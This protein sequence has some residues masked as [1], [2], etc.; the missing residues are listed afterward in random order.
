LNSSPSL[1]TTGLGGLDPAFYWD[2]GF[3]INKVPVPPFVD[4][5]FANGQGGP[6][7]RPKDAN[8]LSYSQQWNLTIERQ[9]TSNLMASVAY[10]ANKGTRLPSQLSPINVLNPN[11]LQT[12]GASALGDQFGPNDTVVNGVPVP[13]AGWYD[14]LTNYGCTPTVAQALSPYPQ[15]CGGL[16]GLNENL[17]SST[18]HSFQLKVEKRFSQGLY[19]LLAYTHSKLLTSAAGLTQS[20]SASWNGTTG[21]IIS[22]FEWNRN[23]SLA[24]DDVPNSFSLAGTYELP[25]GKGKKFANSSNGMNYLVGGWQLTGAWKYS[26]GTPFWFRAANCNVP[27]QFRLT[28]IPAVNSGQD[29][30][31]VPLDQYDPGS[32]KP[33]FNAAA[34]EPD[35]LFTS[36]NYYG[37]GPRVS[38]FR[39]FPFRN[40][41]IGFGKK[42]YIG[43]RVNFTIRAEAFNAFNLHNFTCTGNGGCQNFNTTVGDVN[44]GAWGGAVSG[45]RNIQLVG[46]IEF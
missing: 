38:G 34:F 14:Q 7:Y 27:G 10:V 41:D 11:L 42:T 46:R 31:L 40:V 8:R 43:E 6:T 12:M 45:P 26:S 5:A 13:Y 20:T 37:S 28:C 35:S 39:G 36:G 23:K 4:P 25:F 16:F 44:F 18:Y 30:F 3:P 1:G 21:G 17:G 33:L 19:M 24:P 9:I 2:Q 15:Y 22:P 29:P 32:G